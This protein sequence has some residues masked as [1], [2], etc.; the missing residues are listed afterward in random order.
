MLINHVHRCKL[1][2]GL[3]SDGTNENV[4]NWVIMCVDGS[5]SV[6]RMGSPEECL[7]RVWMFSTPTCLYSSSSFSLDVA[8]FMK[9]LSFSSM[10]VCC[11][12]FVAI[13]CSGMHHPYDGPA[14]R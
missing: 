12:G 7:S 9:D 11:C 5:F 3:P 6:V 10:A 14:A 13:E 2:L 4:E 8:L 1:V